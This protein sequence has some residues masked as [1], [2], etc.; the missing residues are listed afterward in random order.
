M[1]LK[2]NENLRI[3]NFGRTKTT[4]VLIHVCNFARTLD[5]ISFSLLYQKK[6]T[7]YSTV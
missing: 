2:Q 5:C 4:T 7:L 6:S 1:H 3:Y